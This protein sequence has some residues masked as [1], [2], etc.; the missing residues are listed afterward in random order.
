MASGDKAGVGTMYNL[1]LEKSD[2]RSV[3]TQRTDLKKGAS[4]KMRF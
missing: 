4:C 2:F 3:A 1:T